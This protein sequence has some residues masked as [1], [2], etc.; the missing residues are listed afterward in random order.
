MLPDGRWLT[1]GRVE[2]GYLLGLVL[3][4]GRRLGLEKGRR[5]CFR[6]YVDAGLVSV[7]SERKEDA[8]KFSPLFL[9]KCDKLNA[10]TRTSQPRKTNQ[11]IP[12]ESIVPSLR[13]AILCCCCIQI[14]CIS[15]WIEV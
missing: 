14:Y 3:T 13:T 10:R 9:I 11:L 8:M 12:R 1:D 2:D 4:D 7:L 6:T 15:L 5:L